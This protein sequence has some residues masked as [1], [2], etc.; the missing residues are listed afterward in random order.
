MQALS[1]LCEFIE[2]CEFNRLSVRVLHM[3]GEQGP[4]MPN[5][6]K[7]IRYIYNRTILESATV[8]A[9]AVSALAKFAA[10]FDNDIRKNIKILL[11][12]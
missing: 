12:R 9:A 7:Y 5:P 10:V 1:H 6:S 2:D 4:K 3:L 8:R 11:N